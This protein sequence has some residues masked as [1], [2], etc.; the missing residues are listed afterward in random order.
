MAF[1]CIY[2]GVTMRSYDSKITNAYSM[3]LR[4][5]CYVQER[6][7]YQKLS[8]K[9]KPN[10]RLACATACYDITFFITYIQ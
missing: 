6:G 8:H 3:Y 2:S 5:S 9:V 7:M 1:V 4:H 10:M